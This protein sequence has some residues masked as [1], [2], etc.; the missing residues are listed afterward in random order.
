MRV[1]IA[2]PY[3][4][5]NPPEVIRANVLRADQ[6]ARDLMAQGHQVYCPHTMSWGWERDKRLTRQQYLELDKSFLRYWA[7]AIYRIPGDSPG[8]DG[9]MAYAKELGLKDITPTA[10]SAGRRALRRPRS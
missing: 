9:E 8:A 7:E 10:A 4:D 5:S 1:F 3:G 6:V 2:G